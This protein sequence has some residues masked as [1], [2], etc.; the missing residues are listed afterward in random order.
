MNAP[1][2]QLQPATFAEFEQEAKRGNVVAVARTCLS[3]SMDPIDAFVKV[4]GPARYAFLLE[5]VEGGEAVA[6]YSF[7]GADPYMI[8]R[9]RA[10]Q[11]IIEREG[12]CETRDEDF[13]RFVRNHFRQNKLADRGDLSPLAGGAVGYLGYGAA[14]WFEPALN[15]QSLGKSSDDAAGDDQKSDD[16]LLMFYRTLVVFDRVQRQMKIVAVV[17]TDEAS[18]SESGLKRLYESAI[19]ETER[20][21]K[22]LTPSTQ[23]IPEEDPSAGG[24]GKTQT[25][26]EGNKLVSSNWNRDDFEQAV[27]SVKEHI[28]AGDCYQV[29]LSQRFSRDVVVGPVSIYRALR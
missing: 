24:P 1:I 12:A 6:T 20:V 5:S 3:Y 4:A 23:S 27:L 19:R 13:T 11:T 15:K 14:N 18:G 17:F 9:G 22:L 16:A 26:T 2:S 10:N 8:V 28:L 21:R 7:L 25:T 29:V